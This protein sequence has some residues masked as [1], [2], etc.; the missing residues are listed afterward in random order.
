[1]IL[2]EFPGTSTDTFLIYHKLPS[3]RKEKL[4]KNNTIFFKRMPEGCCPATDGLATHPGVCGA[5]VLGTKDY[6]D[7]SPEQAFRKDGGC[8]LVFEIEHGLILSNR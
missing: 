6:Q 1:M 5:S 3:R 2:D 4:N 7:G 8:N